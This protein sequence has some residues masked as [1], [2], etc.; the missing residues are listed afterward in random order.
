MATEERRLTPTQRLHEV[1]LAALTRNVSGQESIELGQSAQGASYIK[2]LHVYRQDGEGWGPF[3][4]RAG[5]M[6]DAVREMLPQA[7]ESPQEPPTPI[8]RP[9]SRPRRETA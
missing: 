7:P 9:R 3:L 4:V 6:F 1:T 2:S 5:N 8:R